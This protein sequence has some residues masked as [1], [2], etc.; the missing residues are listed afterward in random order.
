[1]IAES[2]ER[3]LTVFFLG[4]PE[5]TAVIETRLYPQVL[6]VQKSFPAA[7]YHI[8]SGVDRAI[9]QDRHAGYQDTRVQ[10]DL[11][12][13]NYTVLTDLAQTLKNRLNLQTF[14]L[15]SSPANYRRVTFFWQTNAD[16][17]DPGTGLRKRSIDFALHHDT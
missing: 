5:L 11:W 6:D 10:L 2:L 4:L 13:K 3:Q 16:D 15:G 9:T 1:M 8:I 7:V 12:G 17:Y 14:L